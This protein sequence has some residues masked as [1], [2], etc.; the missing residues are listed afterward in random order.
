MRIPTM[1]DYTKALDLADE[2]SPAPAAAHEA[3]LLLRE[4]CRELEAKIVTAE[5]AG[6]N[7][8]MGFAA[9]V[10]ELF[11]SVDA[12]AIMLPD[13]WY[14]RPIARFQYCID[15]DDPGVGIDASRGWVLA[16][17]Q[18]NTVLL[19]ILQAASAGDAHGDSRHE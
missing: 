2:V 18:S 16:D 11:A 6:E 1:M 13:D 12:A 10:H 14:G 7:A 5:A 8:V 15:V 9:G 17:D 3:L 4:R 19:H